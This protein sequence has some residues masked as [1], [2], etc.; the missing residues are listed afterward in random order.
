MITVE[1]DNKPGDTIPLHS[2]VDPSGGTVH[3]DTPIWINATDEGGSGVAYIHFEVWYNGEPV[4]TEEYYNDSLEMQ[5]QDFGIYEGAADLIF[6]AAD[7]AGNIESP[8][9]MCH[10]T[11]VM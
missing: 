7:N 5:F 11:V 8:P 4:H 3:S 9:N 10:Y 2:W 1:V 6:W